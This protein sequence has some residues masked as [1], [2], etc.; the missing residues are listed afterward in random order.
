M[1]GGA[2]TGSS[3]EKSKSRVAERSALG[4]PWPVQLLQGGGGFR[5]RLEVLRRVGG[6]QFPQPRLDFSGSGITSR[7]Q[8]RRHLIGVFHELANHAFVRKRH[9]AA[10]ALIEHATEAVQVRTDVGSVRIARCS[11][12]V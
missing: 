9:A 1:A 10:K 7:F 12:A 5:G 4:M 6:H 3:I 11:G 8:R 2:A